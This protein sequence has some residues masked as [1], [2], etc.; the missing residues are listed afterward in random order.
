MVV[1]ELYDGVLQVTPNQEPWQVATNSPI[2]NVPISQRKAD[3]WRYPRIYDSLESA[4]GNINWEDGM[5]ILERIVF[6][7]PGTQWSSLYDL[8]DKKI[9]FALDCNFETFFHFSLD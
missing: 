6:Y 1:L 5:N 9:I 2:Y 8:I 7:P 3:C 4:E